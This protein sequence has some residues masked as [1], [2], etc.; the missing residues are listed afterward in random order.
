MGQKELSIHFQ[1]MGELTDELQEIAEEIKNLIQ[2]KGEEILTCLQ[3]S[4]QGEGGEKYRRKEGE[5]LDDTQQIA[6]VF[7]KISQELKEMT[8]KVY[9]AEKSNVLLGKLRE[10][11]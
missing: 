7:G 8:E 9:E 5:L 1:E 4:W 3:N 10:Y 6:I 2:G 11:R